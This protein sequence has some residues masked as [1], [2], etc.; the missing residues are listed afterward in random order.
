MIS[1]AKMIW[2]KKP[3]IPAQKGLIWRKKLKIA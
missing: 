2:R 3:Q 1:L